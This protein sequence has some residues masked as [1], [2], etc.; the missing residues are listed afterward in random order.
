MTVPDIDTLNTYDGAKVNFAN[1]ED[2]T[3]DR[4]ATA[5]NQAFASAAGMT[6]TAMRAMVRATLATGAA[7]TLAN[8][9]PHDALWLAATSTSPTT[10]RSGV[11]AVSFTW[12]TTVADEIA[13]TNSHTL[14]FRTAKAYMEGLNGPFFVQAIVTA[15]NVVSVKIW[16]NTGAATDANGNVLCVQVY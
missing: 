5:A 3:T 11:G 4:D 12:P 1:V 6:H 15:P 14:N 10:A 9:N 2:P 16:D 13:A 8:V 7:P